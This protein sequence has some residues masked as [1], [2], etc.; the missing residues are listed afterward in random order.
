[1]ISSAPAK[2]IELR[3]KRHLAGGGPRTILADVYRDTSSSLWT[4]S[5]GVPRS[6]SRSRSVWVGVERRPSRSLVMSSALTQ[7]GARGT[8][9]RV[10]EPGWCILASAPSDEAQGRNLRDG[11]RGVRSPTRK[12]TARKDRSLRS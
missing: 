1:M 6:A 5:Y 2:M 4:I 9:G 10:T 12:N 11:E 3:S 8:M 7:P